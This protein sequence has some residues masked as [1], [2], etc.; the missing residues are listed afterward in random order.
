[1]AIILTQTYHASVNISAKENAILALEKEQTK[2]DS[3][4]LTLDKQKQALLLAGQE[5]ADLLDRNQEL[6]KKLEETKKRIQA[7]KDNWVG[8]SKTDVLEAVQ[9]IYNDLHDVEIEDKSVNNASLQI[10]LNKSEQKVRNLTQQVNRLIN[11]RD[12]YKAERDQFKNLWIAEKNKTATANQQIGLLQKQIKTNQQLLNKAKYTVQTLADSINRVNRNW[13]LSESEKA[14]LIA[15]LNQQKSDAQYDADLI[16]SLQKEQKEIQQYK[17]QLD[18][19]QGIQV[20]GITQKGNKVVL[21]TL[22]PNQAIKTLIIHYYPS[23]DVVALAKTRAS[24]RFSWMPLGKNGKSTSKP[25]PVRETNGV[26]TAKVYPE[27]GKKFSRKSQ[28]KLIVTQ[29]GREIDS[30]I[31]T[32][33]Q[34]PS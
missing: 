10:R 20:S 17:D 9:A 21:K 3:L 27:K 12:Q 31:I 5:S 13:N 18:K 26:Y 11:Q 15:D 29:D 33:G 1:M 2:V 14:Q 4:I 30:Q 22:K 8:M 25:I 19:A 32:I 34:K 16:Q 7:L 24:I 28:Y 23:A 6:N